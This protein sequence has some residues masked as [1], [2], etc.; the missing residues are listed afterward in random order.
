[1]PPRAANPAWLEVEVGLCA[2]TAK[3]RTFPLSEGDRTAMAATV[4]C[5]GHREDDCR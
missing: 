3:K 5:N 4:R 1:M 2:I